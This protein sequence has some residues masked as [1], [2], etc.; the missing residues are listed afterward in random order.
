[1]AA[2]LWWQQRR[3]TWAQHCHGVI[4]SQTII[5]PQTQTSYICTHSNSF[6]SRVNQES[7]SIPCLHINIS[8]QGWRHRPDIN[9]TPHTRLSMSTQH[10]HVLSPGSPLPRPLLSDIWYVLLFNKVSNFPTPATFM[11][12]LASSPGCHGWHIDITSEEGRLRSVCSKN[13]W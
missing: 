6:I 4:S 10:Q 2:D 12:Q 3:H 7:L 1:M 9:I 5:T 8:L 11:C 13:C